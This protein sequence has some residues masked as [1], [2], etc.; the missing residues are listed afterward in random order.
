MQDEGS[1]QQARQAAIGLTHQI[2]VQA[3]SKKMTKDQEE[4]FKE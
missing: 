2:S 3:T 1:A 4:Q